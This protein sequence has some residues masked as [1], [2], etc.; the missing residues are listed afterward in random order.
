MA[1]RKEA[2]FSFSAI[3]SW[4]FREPQ[5]D[6]LIPHICEQFG[7]NFLSNMFE[8]SAHPQPVLSLG[9]SNYIFSCAN[10]ANVLYVQS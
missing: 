1:L 9:T 8:I 6:G 3:Q 4:N 2:I 10:Q 5:V 7:G